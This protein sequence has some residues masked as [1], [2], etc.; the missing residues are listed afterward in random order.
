M[1]RWA[2]KIDRSIVVDLKTISNSKED[3]KSHCCCSCA[4]LSHLYY[5]LCNIFF[6]LAS[7]R[8]F[9]PSQKIFFFDQLT[10]TNHLKLAQ[11][12]TCRAQM[13]ALSD[14]LLNTPVRVAGC[15]KNLCSSMLIKLK[16]RFEWSAI[17]FLGIFVQKMHYV[18]LQTAI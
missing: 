13:K 9:L 11:K 10:L 17:T 3:V 15:T 1:A 5:T 12:V 8:I 6:V 18:I 2:S 7:V 14:N 4:P 16:I